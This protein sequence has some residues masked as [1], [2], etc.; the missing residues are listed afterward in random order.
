MNETITRDGYPPNLLSEELTSDIQVAHAQN[1]NLCLAV[2]FQR[3]VRKSEAWKLFVRYQ[4]QT[5]RL[6]RRA[7]EEFERLKKLRAEPP[8]E[9]KNEANNEPICR[10]H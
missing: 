3:A 4:A 7:V 2:G 9:A 5:E 6:Y 8:N 1:R 10:T